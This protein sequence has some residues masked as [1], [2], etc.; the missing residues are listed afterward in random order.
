MPEQDIF[1]NEVEVASD[2]PQVVEARQY[3]SSI[4]IGDV[5]T[6]PA[7]SEA[8]V[9]NTGT[10]ENAI[11]NFGLPKGDAGSM[12]G[13]LAGNIGDQADL[14]TILTNQEA[15][16][17]VKAPLASPALTGTPT[18]P[19][20]VDGTSSTQI[21]TTAFVSNAVTNLNNALQTYVQTYVQNYVN[22]AVAN[23]LKIANWANAVNFSTITSSGGVNYN[24]PYTLPSDG[25]VMFNSAY[26]AYLRIA[27][28]QLN[29]ATNVLYPMKSGTVISASQNVA[30]NYASSGVFI[31]QV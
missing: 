27:G 12:W 22:Q 23:V 13:E 21:A 20:A 4:T 3:T 11:L 30:V 29:V 24:T 7:G 8:T 2:I 18:A 26:L 5:T 25:Y 10:E 16:I 19:T 1:E 31:P 17:N 28:K 14:S 15:A 6:L 9:T